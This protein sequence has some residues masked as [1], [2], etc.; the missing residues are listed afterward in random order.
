MKYITIEEF[1]SL[2]MVMHGTH[3]Y[4]W[5]SFTPKHD[6]TQKWGWRRPKGSESELGSQLRTR[7]TLYEFGGLDWRHQDEVVFRSV[8][9]GVFINAKVKKGNMWYL[10][11]LLN[12]RTLSFLR[13][14]RLTH[15]EQQRVITASRSDPHICI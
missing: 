3:E 14:P 1:P 15:T 7:L 4:T 2:G 5:P 8:S 12:K 6:D 9:N 11:L 13:P 10:Y